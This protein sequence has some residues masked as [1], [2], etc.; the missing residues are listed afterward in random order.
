MKQSRYLKGLSDKVRAAVRKYH[1]THDWHDWLAF[2]EL[3]LEYGDIT[4]KRR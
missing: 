3:S 4:R 1:Q 2:E